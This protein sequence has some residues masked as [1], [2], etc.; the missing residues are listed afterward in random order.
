MKIKNSRGP[1][2]D[3]CGTP[4]DIVAGVDLEF[5]TRTEIVRSAKKL[6]SHRKRFPCTPGCH[7]FNSSR[8]WLTLSNVFEKS[9]YETSVHLPESAIKVHCDKQDRMFVVHERWRLKPC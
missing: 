6:V 5:C 4:Q 3:P 8:L 2:T 7:S 9:N 1:S